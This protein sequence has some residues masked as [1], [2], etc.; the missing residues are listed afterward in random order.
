MFFA[1]DPNLLHNMSCFTKISLICGPLVTM[2]HIGYTVLV[3]FQLCVALT[4]WIA[5]PLL[6]LE[7][8]STRSTHVRNRSVAN[9]LLHAL[10]VISID[11]SYF[12]LCYFFNMESYATA[13]R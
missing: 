9:L 3:L 7:D 1:Q 13:G 12:Y 4:F 10:V 6:D 2:L 5:I 8:S 11:S